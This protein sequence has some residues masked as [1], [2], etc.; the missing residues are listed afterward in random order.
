MNVCGV[1]PVF[2]RKLARGEPR[3]ASEW[4]GAEYHRSNVD[5]NTPW[6]RADR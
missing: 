3:R 6:L 5:R 2:I 4:G 1:L